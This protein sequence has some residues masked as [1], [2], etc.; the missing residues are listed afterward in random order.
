MKLIYETDEGVAVS[1]EFDRY[2]GHQKRYKWRI[3]D[4]DQGSTLAE[5]DDLA[6][7]SGGDQEAL[8]ALIGFIGAWAESI[9]HEERTGGKGENSDMFPRSLHDD[10]MS[11][12]G[13]WATT[14]QLELSG[15]Y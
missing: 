2:D 7:G 8:R 1:V 10:A 4:H 15:N 5:G 13:D 14:A 9:D 11:D 6:I 3:Y 12:W